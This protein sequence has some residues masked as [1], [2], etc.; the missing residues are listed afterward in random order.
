MARKAVEGIGSS[1]RALRERSKLSIAEVSNLS[2]LDPSYLSHLELGKITNPTLSTLAGIA[3]AFKVPIA[4]LL[5]TVDVGAED[6][7]F[8]ITQAVRVLLLRHA[9]DHKADLL[10]VLKALRDPKR[11]QAVRDLIRR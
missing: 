5:N 4:E 1:I 7:D 10:A 3:R 2:G 9:K 8:Q 6:Q 11:L